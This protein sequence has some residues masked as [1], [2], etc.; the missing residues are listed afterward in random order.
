MSSGLP[1][2]VQSLLTSVLRL[3][4]TRPA[5]PSATRNILEFCGIAPVRTSLVGTV[6]T[7]GRG[8]REIWLAKMQGLGRAGR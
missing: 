8:P 2:S 6:E 1:L 7:S 5:T 3:A 4:R